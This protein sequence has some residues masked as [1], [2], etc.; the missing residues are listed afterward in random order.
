M[1]ETAIAVGFIIFIIRQ[2]YEKVNPPYKLCGGCPKCHT[3]YFY[4]PPRG[5]AFCSKC[6]QEIF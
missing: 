2:I 1:L 4:R 3:R 6:G 5:Q